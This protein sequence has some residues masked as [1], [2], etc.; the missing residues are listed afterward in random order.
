MIWID[1]YVDCVGLSSELVFSVL[2]VEQLEFLL[3]VTKWAVFVASLGQ[4]L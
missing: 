1:F 4:I 3:E 2:S